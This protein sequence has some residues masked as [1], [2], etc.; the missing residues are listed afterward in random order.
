MEILQ[1][2]T[3]LEARPVYLSQLFC[4]ESDKTLLDCNNGIRSVGLAH[5][6]L[7]ENVWIRCK[8]KTD[9]KRALSD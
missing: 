2:E 3:V 4:T 7:E 6:D 5:C 9:S 8:G 1:P